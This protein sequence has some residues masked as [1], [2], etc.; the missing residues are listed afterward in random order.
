VKSG[1][2]SP[3]WRFNVV[4]D[5]GGSAM[6]IRYRVELNEAERTQLAALLGA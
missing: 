6:N 4:L 3:T 5:S 1:G 2:D